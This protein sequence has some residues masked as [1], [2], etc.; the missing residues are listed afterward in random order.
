MNEVECLFRDKMAHVCLITSCLNNQSRSQ[1]IN[2]NKNRAV[3]KLTLSLN[4][5]QSRTILQTLQYGSK[6][7]CI[8]SKKIFLPKTLLTVFCCCQ[9]ASMVGAGVPTVLELK[10]AIY[11]ARKIGRNW[12]HKNLSASYNLSITRKNKLAS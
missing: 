8:A 7:C 6:R 10:T 3:D 2:N 5:S 11:Q 1:N 9:F 4:L 12:L